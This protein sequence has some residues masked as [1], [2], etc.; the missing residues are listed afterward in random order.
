MVEYLQHWMIEVL[1]RSFDEGP[2]YV[3]ELNLL[4]NGDYY[5]V[6]SVNYL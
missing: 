6:D 4:N 1:W 5:I 3:I 2:K